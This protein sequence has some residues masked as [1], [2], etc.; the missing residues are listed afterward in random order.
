MN[1]T[2]IK[3]RNQEFFIVLALILLLIC[4]EI[5]LRVTESRLSANISNIVSIPKIISGIGKSQETT[6]LF[7]GNSLTDNAVNS[8]KLSHLLKSQYNKSYDIFKITPDSS[9]IADWFCIYRNQL[10][11]INNPPSV[12][13]IGFAWEQISD[14]ERVHP[15]RLGGMFCSISDLQPLSVTELGLHQKQL[16]FFAG[17]ISHVFVNR[18]A[19][20]NRLLDFFIPHYIKTTRSINQ[21]SNRDVKVKNNAE[22]EYSYRLLTALSAETRRQGTEIIL[23]AMPVITPYDVDQNL[24]ETANEIGVKFI[25]LRDTHLKSKEHYRDPIHLN[26][27]GNA[28]F[29]QALSNHLSSILPNQPGKDNASLGNTK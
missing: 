12:I 19:I 1:S 18:E 4:I 24:I 20:R 26:D 23:M 7:V 16:H 3:N 6:I 11:S 28:I 14:Q 13:I 9:G 21:Y 5:T 2:K 15:S 22:K 10:K 29:T 27:K 8:S 25:D 17:S